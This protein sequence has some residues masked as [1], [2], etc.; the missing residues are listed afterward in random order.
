MNI[1]P[2]L[3]RLQS[4]IGSQDLI[5]QMVLLPEP[6][7]QPY[8]GAKSTKAVNLVVGYNSSPNSQTALD[9]TL[10][11]AH[12]TRLATQKQVTV[13]VVYVVDDNQNMNCPDFFNMTDT[14]SGSIA[15]NQLQLPATA[16]LRCATP[17]LPQLKPKALVAQPC[18]T[19]VD[20]FDQADKILWQARC[21][22]EEWGGAF[23]AH[24]RF[25]CIAA[26]LRKVVESEAANVLLLGCNSSNHPIVQKLD[27]NFPCTVLGM[28]TMLREAEQV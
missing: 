19:P 2:M 25:G 27:C 7:S 6:V 23:I 20:L 1:K 26:E 21:L 17:V 9:I 12:Q 4:A 18:I 3:M 8:D 24:L 10:C 13:H 28:P 15:W 5:E 14:N 16:A 11:I 22:A